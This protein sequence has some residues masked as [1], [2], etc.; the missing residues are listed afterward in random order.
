MSVFHS[1]AR[2]WAR[3]T[4]YTDPHFALCS[5]L[6]WPIH[7]ENVQWQPVH[8]CFRDPSLLIDPS[9]AKIDPKYKPCM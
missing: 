1:R 5:A 8:G 7:P 6:G 4:C 9:S 3:R 2:K